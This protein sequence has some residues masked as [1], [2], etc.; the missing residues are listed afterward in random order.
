MYKY[1]YDPLVITETSN[2]QDKFDYSNLLKEKEEKL[3][4]I[5]GRYEKLENECLKFKIQVKN[6]EDKLST[7]KE[8]EY[9]VTLLFIFY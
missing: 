1:D 4:D 7:K 3:Q 5:T 9:S 8:K 6:L 2:N